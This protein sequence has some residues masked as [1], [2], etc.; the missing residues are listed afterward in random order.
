MSGIH[1]FCRA[2]PNLLLSISIFKPNCRH[3]LEMTIYT[4]NLHK[5][6]GTTQ[7]SNEIRIETR[8]LFYRSSDSFES[9]SPLRGLRATQRRSALDGTTK[10]TLARVFFN[11]FSSFHWLI[12]RRRNRPLQTFRGT[13]Q[14]LGCSPAM[15]RRLGPK[16][17]RVTNANHEIDNMHKCSRVGCSQI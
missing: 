14:S 4:E 16:S 3:L 10:V 1:D 7:I 11:S 12:P 17:P 13:P 5:R 15:P 6:A 8:Y 2:T 9:Y